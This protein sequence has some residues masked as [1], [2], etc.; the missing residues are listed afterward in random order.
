MKKRGK[1]LVSKIVD[2]YVNREMT[3]REIAGA[4]GIS[5]GAVHRRLIARK[6]PANHKRRH[7]SLR[8][9]IGGRAVHIGIAE[10]K[11]GRPREPDE[12]V[13]HID[14]DPTN[15]HPQNL[16]LTTKSL[17]IKLHWQLQRLAAEMV[18]DGRIIFDEQNM[19]YE[20]NPNQGE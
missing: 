3:I 15:N 12:V 9:T 4:V 8:P 11:Y 16:C 10:E 7:P 2:M 20:F 19:R 13:H 17:H 1:A 6:I 14:L 18:K 5:N